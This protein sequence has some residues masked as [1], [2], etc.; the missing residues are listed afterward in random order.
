MPNVGERAVELFLKD[1]FCCAEAVW[2]ALAESDNL[3]E[4]ERNIGNK[5]ATAW[6]GGTGASD[7]C[8]ALAGGVLV[9]G[10]YFGRIPGEGRNDQLPLYTKA[11]VEAFKTEYNGIYCR[12]LKP[13]GEP[14]EVRS[15]CSNFVRF[16][17]D[18]VVFL[19]DNGLEDEDCG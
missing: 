11:L 8:G 18:Q 17:A 14:D 9:L 5:L 13:V 3:P 16:V 2:L 15:L 7:M 19:L 6:C 10:R 1:K 4:D 12:D